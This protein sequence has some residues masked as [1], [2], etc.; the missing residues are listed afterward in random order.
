[1]VSFGGSDRPTLSALSNID[2]DANVK[3]K[4]ISFRVLI[5][6]RPSDALQTINHFPGAA[7]ATVAIRPHNCGAG[8][9]PGARAGVKKILETLEHPELAEMRKKVIEEWQRRNESCCS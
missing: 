5:T 6:H 1:V 4:G 9:S 7:A 8:Q 2:A 3:L